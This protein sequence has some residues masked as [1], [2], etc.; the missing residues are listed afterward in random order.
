MDLARV[1]LDE[2]VEVS[3]SM[4]F[5]GS[6]DAAKKAG[7][8]VVHVLNELQVSCKVRDIPEHIRV[9]LGTMAGE[10]LSAGDI[11][12]PAGTKLA[13]SANSAVIRVQFA[14]EEATTAEAAAPAAEAAAPAAAKKE[15]AKK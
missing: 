6:P 8:I 3:V 13:T 2:V 1:N 15:E 14:K 12:L 4:E 10:T 5:V 11:P 9:D 7:A